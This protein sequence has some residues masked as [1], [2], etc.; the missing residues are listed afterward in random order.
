LCRISGV[1]LPYRSDD[2]TI[3]SPCPSNKIAVTALYQSGKIQTLLN[4]PQNQTPFHDPFFH[5]VLRLAGRPGNLLGDI[6]IHLVYRNDA[7][8]A[9]PPDMITCLWI[10]IAEGRDFGIFRLDVETHPLIRKAVKIIH[11]NTGY[12]FFWRLMEITSTLFG[13][14]VSVPGVLKSAI[15]LLLLSR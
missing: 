1:Q 7:V 10:R 6:S 14:D 15:I 2:I 3:I 8:P 5:G 4:N 12:G 13:Y 11:S 9:L